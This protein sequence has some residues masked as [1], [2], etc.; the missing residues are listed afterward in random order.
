[1]HK[2]LVFKGKG[3]N[4]RSRSYQKEWLAFLCSLIFCVVFVSHA[5]ANGDGS[6]KLDPSVI[7][8][9][10]IQVGANGDFSIRGQLF[11]DDINKASKNI[12]QSQEKWMKQLKNIDFQKENLDGKPEIAISKKLFQNYQPQVI[13][14]KDKKAISSRK[15][16]PLLYVL[17]GVVLL[18]FGAILGKI[19]VRRR[20]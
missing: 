6:L 1:M 10:G 11:S 7:T 4:F 14:S 20:K 17:V 18:I 2:V 9:N 16:V 12:Q 8:N 13:L 15:P 3:S 5:Y 19:W